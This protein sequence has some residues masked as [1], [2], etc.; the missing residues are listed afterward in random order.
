[1][2]VFFLGFPLASA[3]PFLLDSEPGQG[4]N[5]PAGTTQIITNYSEAVEIGFSEL[6]V[7]DANGNQIDNKDTAYNGGETSLIVTTPP[8]EDGVYTCLLYTSDAAD[9]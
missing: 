4:Q 1:M 5:A 2:L 9:E 8:L 3:H 7:Y 6:K